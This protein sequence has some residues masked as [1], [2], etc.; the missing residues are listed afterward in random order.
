MKILVFGGRSDIGKQ[1][2]IREVTTVLLSHGDCDIRE[3]SEV[4][5][6]V[7]KFKPDVVINCA[8]IL[9]TEL[10]SKQKPSQWKDEMMINLFG[11][12]I[13]AQASIN[14]NVNTIILI[15]SGAGLYGKASLAA[16]SASKAGVISLT[17]SL[18]MEGI[19]AYC[20]SPGGVDTKMREKIFPGEDKRKRLSSDD[21]VEVM[22]DCIGGKYKP[23]DNIIIRKRNLRKVIRVDRGQPWKEYFHIH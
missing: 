4:N 20:I 7:G 2:K 3:P 13:I 16:Y 10:V 18:G 5:Y 11:S 22:F 8:G 15:G 19:N 23:G 17:Q 12:F 9:H 1:I 6:F 21:V 14:N